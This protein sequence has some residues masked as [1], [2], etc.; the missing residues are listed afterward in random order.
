MDFEDI[1]AAMKPL[2]RRPDPRFLN[3]IDG[4]EVDYSY[5]YRLK[6]ASPKTATISVSMDSST[7]GSLTLIQ[8]GRYYT[9]IPTVVFTGLSKYVILDV[10]V[11]GPVML[12]SSSKN[13]DKLA[14]VTV[15][16]LLSSAASRM[17]LSATSF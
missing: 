4:L 10:F 9:Q 6:L 14:S 8:G 12:G 7:V 16:M 13:L 3:E 15:M 1:S 2:L 17:I 11:I 5:Q